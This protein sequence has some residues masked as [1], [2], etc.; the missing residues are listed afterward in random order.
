MQFWAGIDFERLL[1]KL[2]SHVSFPNFPTPA[3]AT[4]APHHGLKS[5]RRL[6]DPLIPSLLRRPK[7]GF[8][9]RT[10]CFRLHPK[11]GRGAEP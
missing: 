9:L 7:L 4:P 10:V 5:P 8:T 1:G 11:G 6:P 3:Q 2:F